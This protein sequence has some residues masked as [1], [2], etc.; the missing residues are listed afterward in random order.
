MKNM[1]KYLPMEPG[2]PSTM[3]KWQQAIEYLEDGISLC[4]IE[5]SEEGLDEDTRTENRIA[6]MKQ[7]RLHKLEVAEKC[8][9]EWEANQ[10]VIDG[11]NER[12]VVLVVHNHG[13]DCSY[14]TGQLRYRADDV[15]YAP[16]SFQLPAHPP[17]TKR[18]LSGTPAHTSSRGRSPPQKPKPKR[19]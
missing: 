17:P 19:R 18:R 8:T 16:T 4:D 11:V 7:S 3:Q 10:K 14:D 2:A 13:L 12:F 5:H 9:T 1:L 15:L 6:S